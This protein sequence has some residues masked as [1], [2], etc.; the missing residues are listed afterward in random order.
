MKVL[1]QYFF[2]TAPQ[3][4]I[5]VKNQLLRRTPSAATRN[6]FAVR[7]KLMPYKI[8]QRIHNVL[9]L[10]ATCNQTTC[11]GSGAAR[12]ERHCDLARG[13]RVEAQ[14][15][16]AFEAFSLKW[17]RHPRP[18]RHT[19]LHH[20]R[21]DTRYFSARTA[22]KGALVYNRPSLFNCSNQRGWC[23]RTVAT[24]IFPSRKIARRPCRF[25]GISDR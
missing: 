11:I 16:P 6:A 3:K 10:V 14:W 13:T 7:L 21:P 23:S 22:A 1:L 12:G 4:L 20:N 8:R 15:Q 25:M 9:R 18:R 17:L 19:P 5:A 24:S 2:Q